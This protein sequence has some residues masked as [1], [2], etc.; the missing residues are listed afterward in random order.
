MAERGRFELPVP[1]PAHRFSR[2]APSTT[3]TPLQPTN[4]SRITPVKLRCCYNTL[5]KILRGITLAFWIMLMTGCVSLVAAYYILGQT[6]LNPGTVKGWL[7]ESGIYNSLAENIVPKLAVNHEEAVAESSFVTNDMLQ[8]A[9]KST[10]K[11]ESVKAKAEPVIDAVYAWLDSKSPEIT[12][13][14]SIEAE[15][16]AFFT[17]LRG[18]ILAKIKT[19]PECTTYVAPEDAVSANCLPF[20]ATPENATDIVM[21]KVREQSTL[22]AKALTPE[23]FTSSGADNAT[24]KL[25][26]LISYLWV[27]QLIAIPIFALIALFVIFKRRAAGLIA[28]G[29]SLLM[30]GLTL[31]ALGLLLLL[32]GGAFIESLVAK[33]EVASVAGPLG[34][35]ITETFSTTSIQA[36][37]VVGGVGAVLVAGGFWWKRRS[38]R[39]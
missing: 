2:A 28:V 27:A 35:V 7:S 11:P 32:G 12:F 25:P 14:V 4:Y 33:S 19:L 16:E 3:Q 30:P 34:K 20:Y 6:I 23:S 1:F 38:K 39:R 9:A 17:A 22:S 21:Q 29:S 36:G 10:F 24:N 8:R 5:M 37:A 26:D 18:E 15:T 31:L 13:S